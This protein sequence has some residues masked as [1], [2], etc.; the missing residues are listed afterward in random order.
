MTRR[1]TRRAVTKILVAAPAALAAGPLGCRTAGDSR[2]AERLTP[3]QKKRRGDLARSV[4]RLQKSI[5]RLDAMEI[6][7]GS[8]PAT[9]FAPLLAKK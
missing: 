3:A 2:P 1:L 5:E 8:E 6:P 7:I 9:Y 4:S